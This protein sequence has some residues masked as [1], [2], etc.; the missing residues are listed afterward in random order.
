MTQIFDLTLRYRPY[1]LFSV[2]YNRE[3]IHIPQNNPITLHL[4]N[5]RLEVTLTTNLFFTFFW[6]YNS[7]SNNINLNARMQ[8][9]FRPMCD[10]FLVWIDN[11]TNENISVKNRAIIG[12]LVIWLNT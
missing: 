2:S 8:W 3:D 11:Y 1:V 5:P 7:Q 9:R 4:I 6:Q 10:F 12:K